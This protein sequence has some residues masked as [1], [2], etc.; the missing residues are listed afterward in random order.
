VVLDVPVD[1]ET[2]LVDE[3]NLP[4]CPRGCGSILRPNVLMFGDYGWIGDRTEEQENRWA[5][6]LQSTK[7]LFD[8]AGL[9]CC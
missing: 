5:E 2:F 8:F 7:V 4:K 1:K 9:L 6:F 3:A